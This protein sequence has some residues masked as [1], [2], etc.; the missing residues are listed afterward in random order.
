MNIL[1]SNATDFWVPSFFLNDSS[2]LVW[3]SLPVLFLFIILLLLS[4]WLVSYATVI[5]YSVRKLHTNATWILM[6]ICVGWFECMIGM[7][8]IF[9]YKYGILS[10]GD[11]SKAYHGYESMH[12]LE[13]EVTWKCAPLVIGTVLMWHYLGLLN[14]GI[15][16]FVI[17][18][19]FATL[20]SSDYESK[21][22]RWLFILLMLNQ[23]LA[24]IV[25]CVLF[26]FHILSLSAWLYI[27][28]FGFVIAIPY[29]FFIRH[30]NLHARNQMRLG[31]HRTN[32]SLAA[33]F[34]TDENVRSM[35]IVTRMAVVAAAFD[36]VFLI[37]MILAMLDT[38]G[39]ETFSQFTEIVLFFH[40]IG[41]CAICIW[42]TP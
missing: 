35:H 6:L 12:V 37:V 9:P 41:P 34:Q 40:R 33:K 11:P 24:A 18:R 7:I 13:I 17:E 27:N 4:A 15:V 28:A 23:Q 36:V 25:M 3:S 29:I 30:Y 32:I 14:G 39:V 42:Y 16:C 10:L 38:P 2:Y 22:R 8:S 21:P 1:F 26:S 31:N 5:V 20:L 19:S